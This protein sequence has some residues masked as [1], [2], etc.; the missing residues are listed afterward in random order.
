MDSVTEVNQ[1]FAISVRDC[2]LPHRVGCSCCDGADKLDIRPKFM[3]T[4]IYH[5]F[6]VLWDSTSAQPTAAAGRHGYGNRC[7]DSISQIHSGPTRQRIRRDRFDH[8][9]RT[10]DGVWTN[11]PPTGCGLPAQRVLL[12]EQDFLEVAPC[13]LAQRYGPTFVIAVE[14][15]TCGTCSWWRIL[16][17]TLDAA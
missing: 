9:L 7:R 16:T 4:C 14:V 6:D 5:K 1:I 11:S 3:N 15:L 17:I 2:T 13:R 12:D 10:R 8:T